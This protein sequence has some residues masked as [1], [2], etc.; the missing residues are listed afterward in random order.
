MSCQEIQAELVAYHFG[1]VSDE[2]RRSLESHLVGCPACLK[3]FLALKREIET[4]GSGPRP[5]DTAR[6]RLRS[7][8]A[9]EL[10]VGERRR[11]WSWWERPLAF[12]FAAVA[13]LLAMFAVNV[14]ASS[15]GSMPHSLRD[16]AR[17]AVH[18]H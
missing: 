11:R 12:S 16:P 15:S 13:V 18:S 14:V 4:A 7:A 8:V 10:G 17:P 2:V 6:Q 5:S 3:A 9:R 1:V